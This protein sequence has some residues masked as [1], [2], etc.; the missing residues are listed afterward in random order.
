MNPETLETIIETIPNAFD[1]Y[2]FLLDFIP[3]E[4]IEYPD[5]EDIM[6]DD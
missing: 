2:P 1:R 6:T 4:E 3:Q 5:L